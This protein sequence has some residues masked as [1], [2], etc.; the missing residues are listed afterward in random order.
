MI[1]VITFVSHLIM[2]GVDIVA[3]K[4]F[5]SHKTLSMVLRY[6]HLAPGH[7]IDAVKKLDQYINDC[8]YSN[9]YSIQKLYN[10]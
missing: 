2:Q 10:F 6:V 8:Y 5:L 7:R 3:V 9:P 1:Y 4:E